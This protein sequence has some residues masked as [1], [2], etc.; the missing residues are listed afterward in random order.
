[1]FRSVFFR[2]YNESVKERSK[3]KEEFEKPQVS[4]TS[5]MRVVD[6]YA[7]LEPDGLIAPGIFVKGGDI[8]IGK[9][10]SE[11]ET[12]GGETDLG[13]KN[14]K[15]DASVECRISESGMVDQVILTTDSENHRFT[16]VRLRSIRIPQ[17]GDKFASRHGQKGVCGMTYRQEDMPFTSE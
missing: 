6:K 4:T 5:S 7:K 10:T 3:L 9:T 12:I 15:K 2:T 16:K 11:K 1:M 13:N 14:K 8:I 17:I